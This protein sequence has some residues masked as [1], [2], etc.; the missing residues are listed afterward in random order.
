MKTKLCK[1]FIAVIALFLNCIPAFANE[2]EVTENVVTDELIPE[3]V[4]ENIQ[5]N[6]EITNTEIETYTPISDEELKENTN[7]ILNFL[8]SQQELSGKILDG[9]TTDWAIISF[10][11][12]NEYAEDIKLESGASLLDFVKS[13]EINNTTELNTCAAYPRR[14]LAL[15]A[16]GVDKNDATIQS[17]VGKMESSECYIENKYGKVGINDDLFALFTLLSFGKDINSSIINDIKNT[18][19]S[20]QTVEGAFTWNGYAGADIT[21]AIINLLAY[22]RQSG[23]AIDDGV[24]ENAKNYLKSQQLEDGGWGYGT[25]DSLTTS[26]V[27]MGIHS[28]GEN[29]EQWKKNGK[30][31]L[32][33]L[34]NLL[35]ENGYYEPSWA[36]GTIDWFATKH[37]IPAL[38][39]KTWP[40]ILEPRITEIP[41]VIGNSETETDT[42]LTAEVE[43]I[44]S[45]GGG[46]VL[47]PK[48]SEMEKIKIEKEENGNEDEDDEI[49][50][51]S[52][53]SDDQ[54]DAEEEVPVTKEVIEMPSEIVEIETS[55][56]KTKQQFQD[57][58]NTQIEI[59]SIEENKVAL[60]TKINPDLIQTTVVTTRL[61][62]TP[63]DLAKFIFGTGLSLLMLLSLYNLKRKHEHN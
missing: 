45:G 14:A 5:Q 18:I 63:K 43:P 12:N 57:S 26:W 2:T 33:P 54:N 38:L 58:F 31:P 60:N 19:L 7:K 46:G 39:K 41:T 24:I 10:A 30:D 21:G 25:S 49:E 62:S 37:A 40:I 16:G 47:I 6:S 13:D 23:I 22:A 56:P 27:L 29:S 48:K 17:L 34:V 61:F 36:P 8:R 35:N 28:I 50:L 42:S 15:L 55:P 44:S 11:A 51:Q 59:K 20:D 3:I 32:S 9:G 52:F 1:I 53:E 4:E